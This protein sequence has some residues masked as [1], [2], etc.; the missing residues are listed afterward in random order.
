M[1]KSY[2]LCDV[3]A[4]AK[5][6]LPIEIYL[7]REHADRLLKVSSD[8]RDRESFAIPKR[9]RPRSRSTYSPAILV[10][11]N[12]Q[13]EVDQKFALFSKVLGPKIR[14]NKRHSYQ[15]Q[16]LYIDLIEVFLRLQRKGIKL[17]KGG[18]L[19]AKAVIEGVG[20]ILKNNF[21]TDRTPDQLVKDFQERRRL[22]KVMKSVFGR[23]ADTVKCNPFT[24]D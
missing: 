2:K 4:A 8:R 17:P 18:N 13:L 12:S 19:S 1:N 10:C 24:D 21:Y 22:G 20:E 11:G 16:R 14:G 5:A 15:F 6:N 3:E 7:Q 9:G 23:V